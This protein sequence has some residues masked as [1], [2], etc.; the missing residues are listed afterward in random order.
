MSSSF[1]CN[2]LKSDRSFLDVSNGRTYNQNKQPLDKNQSSK[3]CQSGVLKTHFRN[4]K[5][6]GK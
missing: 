1:K 5:K 6:I 2:P 3:F 4:L